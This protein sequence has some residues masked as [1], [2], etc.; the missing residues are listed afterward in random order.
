MFIMKDGDP[1]QRNEIL[2]ALQCVFRN[3]TEGTCGFHIVQFGWKRHCPGVT[4]VEL[5]QQPKFIAFTK[6]VH[7]WIYSW[8]SQGYCED[9]DEYEISKHLLMMYVSSEH[10]SRICGGN[11]QIQARILRFLQ[12]HVFVYDSLFLYFRRK[13][14]RTLFVAHSSGHEGTNKGIK[15]HAS[16][17]RPTMG[18]DTA[19]KA[20]NV[21]QDI[22]A[23]ELD[24]IFHRDFTRRDKNFSNLPTC[25]YTHR[26]AESLI[27]IIHNRKNL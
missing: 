27:N 25:K 8:M 9:E 1:Q 4:C 24:A 5:S 21:Q 14:I 15:D 11:L 19:A 17:V 20:L 2:I 7:N 6:K 22:K 12:H 18:M 26:H 23:A 13:N 10:V 3:A 16:A